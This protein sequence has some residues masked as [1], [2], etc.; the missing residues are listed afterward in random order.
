MAEPIDLLD[1]EMLLYLFGEESLNGE[2][3]RVW[4]TFADRFCAW[5]EANED[6]LETFPQ[7][8]KAWR[9]ANDN[10]LRMSRES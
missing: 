3:K 6:N 9:E 7:R 2:E 10:N 1:I 5:Y 4:G 8:L